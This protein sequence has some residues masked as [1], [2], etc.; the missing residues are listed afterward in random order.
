LEKIQRDIKDISIQAPNSKLTV[1]TIY[2]IMVVLN[3]IQNKTSL[4][5]EVWHL[6]K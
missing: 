3:F 5:K 4:L 1:F 2:I 6:I